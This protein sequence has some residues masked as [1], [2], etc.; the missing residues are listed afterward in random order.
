MIKSSLDNKVN[1]KAKHVIGRHWDKLDDMIVHSSMTLQPPSIC[2]LLA[3]TAMFGFHTW[4][5]DIRQAYLQVSEPLE[6]KVSIWNAAP[7]FELPPEQ[8]LMLLRP[9]YVL[10]DAGDLWYTT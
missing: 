3:L 4:T 9:L 8:F 5:S 2:L 7:E 1:H 6:R 10:C